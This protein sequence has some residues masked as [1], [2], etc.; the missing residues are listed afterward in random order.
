MG[1]VKY[2]IHKILFMM[3]YADKILLVIT[4]FFSWG[5]AQEPPMKKIETGELRQLSARQLRLHYQKLFEEMVVSNY[6]ARVA[7]LLAVGHGI[8]VNSNIR[9]ILCGKNHTPLMV[10]IENDMPEM[11]RILLK[12]GADPNKKTNCIN[13]TALH[14]CI[15]CPTRG[16]MLEDLLSY[17][18]DPR[19]DNYECA[20]LLHQIFPEYVAFDDPIPVNFIRIILA[21]A[22][23][24]GILD[25]VLDQRDANGDTPLQVALTN[26]S[27]DAIFQFIDKNA[28]IY[29]PCD[30]GKTVAEINKARTAELQDPTINSMIALYDWVQTGSLPE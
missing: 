7:N 27:A 29:R 12:A 4:L 3:R 21:H 6:Y 23:K 9:G 17:G 30:D 8:N 19:I 10:A 14:I 28:L 25:E 5:L 15:Q 22:E 2:L 11:V 1:I 13:A 26:E 20:P 18:A 24:K 16:Q